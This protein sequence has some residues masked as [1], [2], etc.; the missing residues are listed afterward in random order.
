MAVVDGFGPDRLPSA[1]VLT[2]DNLGEASALERG[3]QP[4]AT[5]RDPS[6]TEALPWLLEALERHRLSATFFVEAINCELYPD[7]VRE[8]AARG[9]EVGHHGWRHETWSELDG[10]GERAALERGAAAFAALGLR[11]RG[12]RPPGGGLTPRSPALLRESGFHWC[13]PAGQDAAIDDGLAIIPFDWDLVDAYHLMGS[14]APLRA[15]RGDPEAAVPPGAL[16]AY[17]ERRVNTA[18][19]LGTLILHPFLMLDDAWAAGVSRLLATI[20]ANARAGR[21]WVVPGNVF[22]DWQLGGP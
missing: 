13:S 6:V 22:A 1:F 14:F 19:G 20:A 12:F 7:A 9:H 18:T 2:F 4:S 5:G 8:I 16:A 11:P 15:A 21:T 17:L 3:E 10:E